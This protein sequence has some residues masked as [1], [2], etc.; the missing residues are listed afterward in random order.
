LYIH[1][2]GYPVKKLIPLF[3]I[4][5]FLIGTIVLAADVPK[6]TSAKQRQS[7]KKDNQKTGKGNPQ[8]WKPQTLGKMSCE[9]LKKA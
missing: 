9:D 6:K 5:L 3:A 7:V 2:G 1:Q 8:P 4:L